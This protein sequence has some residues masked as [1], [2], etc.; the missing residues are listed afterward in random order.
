[1]MHLLERIAARFNKAGVPLMALKGAA[2]NLTLYDRPDARPMADLDLM[3]RPED[4]DQAFA[5]LEELGG[6][7]G[8]AL[9]REDFFPRFH[10]EV[11]YTVGTIY[12]VK[13]DLHIRPFRPLRYAQSVPTN[14][15]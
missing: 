4:V 15:L 7:R 1:M 13:I 6:L 5:L 9:V 8:E 12:P 11:E 14:A 10:Y 2:L 3:I